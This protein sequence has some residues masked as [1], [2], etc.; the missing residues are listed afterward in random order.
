MNFK[1][2]LASLLLILV[3]RIL[4][5]CTMFRLTGPVLPRVLCVIV[6]DGVANVVWERVK[7][8]IDEW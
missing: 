5:M 2:T 7:R 8:A 1:K 3:V 4:F 6:F